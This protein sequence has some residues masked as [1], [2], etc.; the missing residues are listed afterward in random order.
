MVCMWLYD[1]PR[2]ATDAPTG[3]CIKNSDSLP[4][5]FSVGVF[6]FLL[7]PLVEGVWRWVCCG[8]RMVFWAGL[9]RFFGVRSP[10]EVFEAPQSVP[11]CPRYVLFFSFSFALLRST[12]VVPPQPCAH[13]VAKSVVMLLFPSFKRRTLGTVLLHVRRM[14]VRVHVCSLCWGVHFGRF[15]RR[16]QCYF[17]LVP[18][19][20]PPHHRGT[21]HI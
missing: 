11:A 8:T 16:S 6:P 19:L 5:P 14:L 18:D 15:L 20:S 12:P 9:R 4:P 1:V 21:R 13:M 17:F 3:S 2:C 7:L 10:S